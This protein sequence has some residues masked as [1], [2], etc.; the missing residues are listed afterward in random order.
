MRGVGGGCGVKRKKKNHHARFKE[1]FKNVLLKTDAHTHNTV[2]PDLNNLA[3]V[4]TLFST[5]FYLEE[6]AR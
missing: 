2:C 3:G 5:S 4:H 1:V 6:S